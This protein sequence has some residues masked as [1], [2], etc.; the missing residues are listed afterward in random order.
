[1]KEVARLLGHIR[2]VACPHRDRQQHHV[3]R[4]ETGD[5]EALQQPFGLCA[6][7][8]FGAL[9]R[10]RMGAIADAFERLDDAGGVDLVVAPVNGEAPLGEVEPCIDHARKLAQSI[11]DLADAAGAADAL[12]R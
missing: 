4:R 2:D 1:M 11:L 3:H 5:G 6:L 8:G 12:D 9:G 7:V 10:E